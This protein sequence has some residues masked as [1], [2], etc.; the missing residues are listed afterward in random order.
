MNTKLTWEE[1]CQILGVPLTATMAEIKARHLHWK[2]LLRTDKK[3]SLPQSVRLSIKDDLKKINAAYD[4]LSNQQNRPN[5]AP[6]KLHITLGHVR[7]TVDTG[8]KKTTTFQIDSIGGPY[9]NFGIDNSPA[10]WLKV[11]E[12]KR[13]SDAPLPVQVTLEATGMG[14]LKK[15][16]EC[17]LPIRIENEPTKIKD[18][19]K[20]KVELNLKPTSTNDSSAETSFPSKNK[21]L[22]TPKWVMALVFVL[23]LSLI[24]FGIGLFVGNYI[25]LWV[26][27]G[28][29][30]IFSLEKWFIKYVT[31]QKATHRI[32]RL[33]LNLAILSLLGLL[34]WSGIQL[35]SHQ[36]FKSA[37]IDS[38]IFIGEFVF[39]V[40]IW[41]IVAKHSSQW[42]SMK[43]TIFSIIVLFIIF[44][45]A[46]VSP[47]LEWKDSFF[48]L[49]RE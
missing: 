13:L 44:A 6:P 38:V 19:I 47:F 36:F 25:S 4:F 37:L 9:T 35:F 48:A 42:P 18:E 16:M 34:V 32:Y 28:F 27:I 5:S 45:F 2:Q 1:A 3:A 49:F 23:A 20:L 26:L 12:I 15:R 21:T 29:A 31:K 11:T 7:F 46:G 33:L 14:I 8:Q 22:N 24:G 10:P 17:F 39:F 41:V 40:W 30:C 43:L